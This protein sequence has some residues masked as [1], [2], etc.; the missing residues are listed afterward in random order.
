[1]KSI[2]IALLSFLL[3]IAWMNAHSAFN[4]YQFDDPVKE[5]RFDKLINEL[6]CTVCQNQTIAGSN[7]DLAK[8]LRDKVYKMVQ[9]GKTEQQIKDFM[10]ERFTDFVLYRPPV[11]KSTYLL[12]GGPFVLLGLALVFLIVQIRKRIQAPAIEVNEH[13]HQRIQELLKTEQKDKQND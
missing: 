12:W 13:Q 8:D 11:K 5:K 7:A 9:E 4:T 10:V 1:M 6:R 3:S 2:S